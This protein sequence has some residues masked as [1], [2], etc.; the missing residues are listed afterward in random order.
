MRERVYQMLSSAQ[1]CV[2]GEDLACA[3]R[4]IVD[5]FE[6]E[7]LNSYERA[8]AWNF[9]AFVDF[10]QDDH[11]GAITAYEN[12]LLEPDVPVAM[13]QQTQYSLVQLYA[14]QDRFAEALATLE[15]W[16]PDAT[17]NSPEPHVL[18]AQIEYGLDDHGASLVA[19]KN[20]IEMVAAAGEEP[21]ENWYQIL[22]ADLWSQGDHEGAAEVMEQMI[23]YWPKRSYFIQLSGIYGQLGNRERQLDLYEAAYGSG[24]LESGPEIVILAGLVLSDGRPEDALEA[25]RQNV[26][27]GVLARGD[28]VDR[29]IARTAAWADG[30]TI[31][32]AELEDLV[33]DAREE[34]GAVVH[35]SAESGAGDSDGGDPDRPVY[36]RL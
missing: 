9:Q 17:V 27:H 22:F 30:E 1:R 16:W 13:R 5:V 6:I 8:Q 14:S 32:E 11:Q 7:D 12:M 28:A 4:M 3:E 21:K 34:A 2:E 19:I 36:R 18:R 15:E 24:W 23:R 10:N 20:A 35:D 25:L 29:L 26:D 33:R 31:D